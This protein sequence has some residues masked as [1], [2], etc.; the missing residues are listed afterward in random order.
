MSPQQ[1]SLAGAAVLK[2]CSALV[3]GIHPSQASVGQPPRPLAAS[4]TC[5]TAALCCNTEPLRT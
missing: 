3:P 2:L 5:G 4:K 1:Y